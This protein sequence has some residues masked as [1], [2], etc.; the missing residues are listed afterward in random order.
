MASFTR[1]SG[2]AASTPAHSTANKLAVWIAIWVLWAVS[3][4]SGETPN[5][6]PMS[7]NSAT[8]PTAAAHPSATLR[9]R[10]VGA[11]S[12]SSATPRR[13]KFR[14]V[15][16]PMRPGNGLSGAPGLKNRTRSTPGSQPRAYSARVTRPTVRITSALP[17]A[18]RRCQAPAPG[19]RCNH[20]DTPARTNESA[21][22]GFMVERPGTTDF[23][24]AMSSIHPRRTSR[25][26]TMAAPAVIAGR[27]SFALA[28][29]TPEAGERGPTRAGGVVGRW[30]AYPRLRSGGGAAPHV[31]ASW[32]SA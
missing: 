15:L 12:I 1:P 17:Q 8:T 11:S 26:T 31:T 13:Q 9:A 20:R 16:I 6:W 18:T 28:A 32:P 22:L 27:P 19:V 14:A 23:R 5:R 24:K 21:V 4:V 29:L 30:Q 3:C 25:P 2:K 10:A 7:A